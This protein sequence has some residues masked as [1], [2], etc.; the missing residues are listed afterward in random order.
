[1]IESL[2][3][4]LSKIVQSVSNKKLTNKKLN[5]DSDKEYLP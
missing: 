4:S 5:Y 1:M 2:R 3:N